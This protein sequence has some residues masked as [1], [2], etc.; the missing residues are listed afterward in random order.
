[1]KTRYL[2]HNKQHVLD[3][4]KGLRADAPVIV[5]TKER[6][7][8]HPGAISMFQVYSYIFVQMSK[9]DPLYFLFKERQD[10]QKVHFTL[11]HTDTVK[12]ATAANN[13]A[14]GEKDLFTT[15]TRADYIRS[16]MTN[17]LPIFN[18]ETGLDLTEGKFESV[19]VEE[20]GGN[21]IYRCSVSSQETWQEFQSLPFFKGDYFI[22]NLNLVSD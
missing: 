10:S 1:M 8:K 4:I 12:K 19:S 5:T 22:I 2:T 18:A 7:P 15:I 13:L 21:P 3:L 20:N 9:D 16:V 14:A 17:L 11:D 6:A